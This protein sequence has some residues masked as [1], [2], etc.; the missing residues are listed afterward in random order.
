MILLFIFIK[1]VCFLLFFAL[2]QIPVKNNTFFVKISSQE[3]REINL[4]LPVL[5]QE[6]IGIQELRISDGG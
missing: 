2:E 3:N 4:H 5:R 1:L 6:L